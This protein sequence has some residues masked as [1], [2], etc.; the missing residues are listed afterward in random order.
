MLSSVSRLLGDE[1]DALFKPFLGDE[2][3]F[4]GLGI[5]GAWVA[6]GPGW[7]W[8]LGGSGAW[9]ALGPGWLWG[10]GGFSSGP[11]VLG[12]KGR[13]HLCW[14]KKQRAFSG[15]A[16]LLFIDVQ[17]AHAALTTFPHDIIFKVFSRL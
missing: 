3:D 12:G 1:S 15:P 4:W 14:I 2:S 9:V 16:T 8:G 11:T 10:L 17:K 7:L 5:S 6:L 13:L